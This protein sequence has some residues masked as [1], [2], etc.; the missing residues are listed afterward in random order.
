MLKRISDVLNKDMNI[1]VRLLLLALSGALTGLTIAF[2]ELG[3][4]EWLTI[5]PAAIILLKRGSDK[6]VN[7]GT[8]YIDGLV[9]FYGFYLVCYHFFLSM[10]PLDF[11]ADVT[12]AEA[13][14][15]VVVAWFGLSLLQSLFGGFVFL[16]AGL[17]F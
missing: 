10:Y 13:A 8:L 17:I 2:P 1:A 5:I 6:K 9:F 12:N 16:L 11:L 3:F 15:V 7:L 14:V 4:L